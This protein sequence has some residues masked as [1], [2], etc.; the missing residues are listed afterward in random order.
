M[1]EYPSIQKS[2]KLPLDIQIIAFDKLDGSNF[3][4]KWSPKKGFH[5]FG[6]R[7]Q[8]VDES[9]SY[10]GGVVSLFKET[11]EEPLHDIF[12]KNF[13]KEKSIIVFSEYYGNNSYAGRHEDEPHELVCFDILK[14]NHNKFILPQDF[15]KLLNNSVKIPEVV[16]VGKST[17]EFIEA[18]R[19]GQY[20][21]KEGVICK[22]TEV[23][24]NYSGGVLMH[25]IKTY[26]YLESLKNRFGNDW[27]K[28]AE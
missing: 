10:W 25:K 1:K 4:A 9:T 13:S 14:E 22:G 6:T 15:I 19:Q 23:Y 21:N 16:Y 7:T 5:L 18:V 17:E 24:G 2:N 20:N 3:R 8:L 27:V 12:F 26:S 11:I 28:Y